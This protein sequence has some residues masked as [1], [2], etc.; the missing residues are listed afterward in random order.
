MLLIRQFTLL[1][2]ASHP[3]RNTCYLWPRSLCNHLTFVIHRT[4]EIMKAFAVAE[5]LAMLWSVHVG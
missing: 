1:V 3:Q 5:I 4:A 2:D